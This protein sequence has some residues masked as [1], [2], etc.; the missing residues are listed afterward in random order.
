MGF[1]ENFIR[2][3]NRIGKTP[4]AVALEVGIAKATVSRRKSGGGVTDATAM[5][6]AD[7]FRDKLP[8]AKKCPKR[9]KVR[10]IRQRRF[11]HDC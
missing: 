9:V 4:C 11:T 3:C 7:Y 1:Y 2:Q 8:V 6:I 10:V 5:K